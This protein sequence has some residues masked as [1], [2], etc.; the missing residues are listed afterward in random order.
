MYNFSRFKRGLKEESEKFA[1]KYKQRNANLSF[2]VSFK[3]FGSEMFF[4]SLD[5]IDSF[6]P[7]TIFM[8]QIHEQKLEA[9]TMF[10][11]AKVSYPT[12]LGFPLELSAHGMS[13]NKILFDF[14]NIDNSWF[15]KLIP[16]FDIS[17]R[18]DLSIDFQFFKKG[19][20]VSSTVHSATGMDAELII[21]KSTIENLSSTVENINSVFGNW[22]N[23]IVKRSIDSQPTGNFSLNLN[24]PRTSLDILQIK[25]ST[26]FT[27]SEPDK[28]E[29]KISLKQ[30][31]KRNTQDQCF[32][33]LL[34]FGAKVCYRAD[35]TDFD[36][37]DFSLTLDLEKKITLV[38]SH[39]INDNRQSLVLIYDTPKSKDQHTTKVTAS[40]GLVPD[41]FGRLEV[42]LANI[43]KLLALEIGVRNSNKEMTVYLKHSDDSQVTIYKGGIMKSANEY[44]PL[45][46]VDTNGHKE[47]SIAGYKVSGK[48]VLVGDIYTLENIDLMTP[49]N[50]KFNINGKLAIGKYKFST[51]LQLN[52]NIS[53]KSTIDFGGEPG[54][55]IGLFVDEN[56]GEI[57]VANGEAD[58][59]V[60]SGEHNLKITGKLQKEK[61]DAQ[62]IWIDKNVKEA[63]LVLSG[64]KI[65]EIVEG[66]ISFVKSGGKS[67]GL[68]FKY[69]KGR[70]FRGRAFFNRHFIDVKGNM[71]GNHISG[72][73][74][75]SGIEVT[76]N[77]LIGDKWTINEHLIDVQGKIKLS[78]DDIETQWRIKTSANS[79]KYITD[80]AVIRN[81]IEWVSWNGDAQV[82]S[83]KPINGKG[84]LKI[85]DLVTTSITFKFNPKNGKGES[86]VVFTPKDA[87][88]KIRFDVRF[89]SLL[90]KFDI[91]SSIA[92]GNDRYSAK[93]ENVVER[94]K[95]TSKTHLS[96]GSSD[97]K[98]Q[99]I[100]SGNLKNDELQGD[101]EL[102]I[103]GKDLKGKFSKKQIKNGGTLE[104]SL[105]DGTDS[106][107]I[108]VKLE[109]HGKTTKFKFNLDSNLFKSEGFFQKV[110]NTYSFDFLGGKVHTSASINPQEVSFKLNDLLINCK[111]EKGVVSLSV[112]DNQFYI[113]SKL[114]IETDKFTFEQE[115]SLDTMKNI[116]INFE[117][118]KNQKTVY[119]ITNGQK[120]GLDILFEDDK[121][122]FLFSTPTKSS[123]ITMTGKIQ[124]HKKSAKWSL[125]IENFLNFSGKHVG[126]Y[127]LED[128]KNVH[129]L[130]SFEINKQIIYQFELTSQGEK[131][132]INIKNEKNNL[133]NGSVNYA[134]KQE[135]HK[136]YIEG[137]G[138]LLVGERRTQANFK[139]MRQSFSTPLDGESGV[140]FSFT[141][142]FD[143]RTTINFLKITD[144][145][146]H[147]KFCLCD[148]KTECAN[149]ELESREGKILAIIDLKTFGVPYEFDLKSNI[150]QELMFDARL[151]DKSNKDIYKVSSIISSLSQRVLL[152]LHSKEFFI[153]GDSKVPVNGLYG[154]YEEQIEFGFD[155]GEKTRILLSANIAENLLQFSGQFIH[156][157]I[158]TLSISSEVNG[159]IKTGDI[160]GKLVYDL[161]DDRNKEI[162]MSFKLEG[163]NSFQGN[164][165]SSGL[166]IDHK[167]TLTNIR[168]PHRDFVVAIESGDLQTLVMKVEGNIHNLSVKTTV[169]NSDILL[170]TSNTSAGLW[171]GSANLLSKEHVLIMENN[172]KYFKTSYELKGVAK[173]EA[174]FAPGN[175]VSVDFSESGG[176]K[177]SG[178]ISLEKERY[179][180]SKSEGSS[181]QL[182]QVLVSLNNSLSF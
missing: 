16:S 28:E 19:V 124:D 107:N 109:K 132:I 51:D 181:K 159:N 77:G 78:Q 36:Y 50:E 153:H 4:L 163:Y 54:Y 105:N 97:N 87:T 10:L 151:I 150:N 143:D 126:N 64:K 75:T 56:G 47:P 62:L 128:L 142:N 53:I 42:E 5:N 135:A 165:V 98:V 179:L 43:N 66:T 91:E 176:E 46:E 131:L 83:D 146:F 172:A 52:K 144:K 154:Y 137:Q 155:K 13:A 145:E 84:I 58:V 93:S 34:I 45:L 129:A 104:I 133:I 80:G 30:K 69:G 100:M 115:S 63:E 111:R 121:V 125:E 113:R 157:Q 167:I 2:D 92:F 15:F 23:K 116:F 55:K 174:I 147:G 94:N 85:Q 11:D 123:K 17:V 108:N 96:C 171:R 112:K 152:K 20:Q 120:Y 59:Q 90:P 14:K 177:Y 180:E 24:V 31:K 25:H 122:E 168:T 65:G 26:S 140:K 166:N 119:F 156:P 32:E 117:H 149:V 101:F 73:I 7:K 39:F 76:L 148:K 27:H 110:E 99:L 72:Q 175:R 3:F 44:Y 127:D 103:P 89:L 35:F 114:N 106:I 61:I 41:A 82:P 70:E 139:V 57:F 162:I 95:F 161:F 60:K 48:V 134:I 182:N 173:I 21:D 169:L 118:T 22:T 136:S 29:K 33:Q 68:T 8:E 38:G 1:K 49:S 178:T 138:E 71:D 18:A 141:G 130:A 81:N 12:G 88:D 102:L 158:K 164:I 86:S 37:A 67:A 170:L 160:N 40:F 79:E 6:D 9:H 74:N